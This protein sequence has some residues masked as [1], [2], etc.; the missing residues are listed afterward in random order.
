MLAATLLVLGLYGVCSAA[1]AKEAASPQPPTWEGQAMAALRRPP[2]HPRRVMLVFPLVEAGSE[3]G[4]IGWGRGLIAQQAMWRSCFA[5]D[6]LLDTYDTYVCKLYQD[7]QLVGPGRTVTPLKIENICATFECPDYTTGTLAV[8]DATYKA[9]LTFHGEHGERKKTYS[10]T[11]DQL[12]KLP[13]LIARDV[14]DYMGVK[15]TPEQSAALDEPCLTSTEQLDAVADYYPYLTENWFYTD[16][17]RLSVVG[18]GRTQWTEDFV[19]WGGSGDAASVEGRIA[20]L[21]GLKDRLLVRY[22]RAAAVWIDASKLQG[23]ASSVMPD[24]T[25]PDAADVRARWKHAATVLL[26]LLRED[27]YNPYLLGLLTRAVGNGGFEDLH[28]AACERYNLVFGEGVQALM[29]RGTMLVDE[30]WDARGSGLAY[31]VTEAG[32]GRFEELLTKAAADLDEAAQIEPRAWRVQGERIAL[33]LGLGRP[34]PNAESAWRAAMAACPTDRDACWEILWYLQPRWYGSYQDVVAKANQIAT[35]SAQ[36]AIPRLLA[37]S[38]WILGQDPNR[39]DRYGSLRSIMEDPD[40]AAQVSDALERCVKANPR[41]FTS[42]SMLLAV[43]Y[44]SEDR[45]RVLRYLR[46]LGEAE[47]GGYPAAL[48]ERYT[49]RYLYAEILDW[50]NH[51]TSSPLVSAARSG[52][53]IA[54]S[55]L[56]ADGADVSK[57]DADGV[58]P[59]VL[60]AHFGHPDAVRVL[61]EAGADLNGR[62]AE[63][64]TAL[65][66]A[67]AQKWPDVTTVLLQHKAD[68]NVTDATGRTPLVRAVEWRFA[69]EVSALLAGGADVNAQNDQKWTALAFAA[70]DGLPQMAT[71]LLDA[72][73][74]PN[75]PDKDGT[76]PLHKCAYAGDAGADTAAI[77]LAHGADLKARDRWGTTALHA[78]ASNGNLRMAM[79]LIDHGADL[80]ARQNQG[81]T[82]LWTA[83]SAGNAE[84]V[85]LLAK[86]GADV[87][88]A[89]KWDLTPLHACASG[90]KV[91]AAKALLAVG[92]DPNALNNDKLTPAALAEKEGHADL[93]ALLRKAEAPVPAGG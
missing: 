77:L 52:R 37:E 28:E 43:S 18:D 67:A 44:W 90:G 3:D 86:K 61:A 62:D 48:D 32:W 68:P 70:R 64:K 51:P 74:D 17:S 84:M 69:D 29:H 73:A 14:V 50:L 81:R 58:P 59:V 6:L 57:P 40:V 9:E 12:Y 5:P 38:Y 30:A 49:N 88:A 60:A 35:G 36:A 16:R 13:C 25:P 54:L 2:D 24:A 82:P 80:E 10:G 87:N 22:L 56:I 55:T 79:L 78:T 1:P 41:D 11:R 92:A 21:P 23:R 63:G 27:P 20:Q 19:L 65:H 76:P 46:T 93:A 26:P 45:G 33:A 8:D 15:L 72:G 83:A 39:E 4:T 85:R 66:W 53:V 34:R 31:T 47:S 7:Q 71:Q 91:E 89:D 42:L 75:L